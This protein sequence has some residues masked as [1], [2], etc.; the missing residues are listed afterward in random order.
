MNIPTENNVAKR[1]RYE[2]DL[3]EGVSD[4]YRAKLPL[5]NAQDLSRCQRGYRAQQLKLNA[6]QRYRAEISFFLAF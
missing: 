2:Y 4:S 5:Q 1:T 6:R 3:E